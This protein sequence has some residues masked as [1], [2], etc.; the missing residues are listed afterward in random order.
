MSHP[1]PLPERFYGLFLIGVAIGKAH[2]ERTGF[3]RT[4]FPG[5]TTAR[6][7]QRIENISNNVINAINAITM[8]TEKTT[9]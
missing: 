7:C 9:A 6:G 5:H 4:Q 1:I 8:P 3:H 2:G